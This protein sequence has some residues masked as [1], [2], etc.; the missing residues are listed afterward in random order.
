MPSGCLTP[1]RCSPS[2]ERKK[3]EERE[4]SGHEDAPLATPCGTQTTLLARLSPGTRWNIG[5]SA[6]G[7][8][9]AWQQVPHKTQDRAVSDS[10]GTSW[11]W[12]SASRDGELG[13]A[14]KR[15]WRCMSCHPSGC[16][17]SRRLVPSSRTRAAQRGTTPGSTS[18]ASARSCAPRRRRKPITQTA[19][20]PGRRAP[21]AACVWQYPVADLGKTSVELDSP[22]RNPT[23]RA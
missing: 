3:H 10:N 16:S 5:H 23:E 2:S 19:K 9:G 7:T 8:S 4:D 17:P 15:A 14:A 6:P 13:S 21:S 12:R 11:L 18:S 1:T 22:H 20:Y